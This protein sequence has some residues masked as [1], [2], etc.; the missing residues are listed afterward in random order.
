MKEYLLLRNNTELGHYSLEELKTM[1]LR[2]FDLIWIENKSFS[3][4]Y[5][6]EISELASFAPPLQL[7]SVDELENSGGSLIQMEERGWN[8]NPDNEPQEDSVEMEANFN[9]VH[10]VAIKP[11]QE[12]LRIKTIKSPAHEK[13]VK[14]QVREQETPIDNLPTLNTQSNLEQNFIK[15][16]KDQA[17]ITYNTPAY[18]HSNLLTQALN[19]LNGNNRMEMMVL[20][21]GAISLLAVIYLFFTSGY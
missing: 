17:V 15:T 20:I 3:W 4:K 1:G 16:Q 9:E 13:I 8:G 19:W 18:S 2:P 12:R 7:P 14:V 21:I 10:I 5:P 6:S 11:K